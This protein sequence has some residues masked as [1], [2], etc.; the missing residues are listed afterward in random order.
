[1]SD[2]ID[3]VEAN[4]K[5]Y[6][7]AI[8]LAFSCAFF[9]S[10]E[11][12]NYERYLSLLFGEYTDLFSVIASVFLLMFAFKNKTLNFG[13]LILVIA[14]LVLEI[15]YLEAF[16][17]SVVFVAIYY[18]SSRYFNPDLDQDM[19]RP[20]MRTFP[21]G[22]KLSKSIPGLGIILWPI[23]R[24]WYYIW[25]PYGL[26]MTHRGVSHWPLIGTLTRVLYIFG[27]IHLISIFLDQYTA[28]SL[29]LPDL[30]LNEDL[31]IILS[32]LILSDTNHF[33]VDMYDSKRKGNG[34]TQGVRKGLIG[35]VI[36]FKF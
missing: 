34:F 32:P 24:A 17:G 36:G 12:Y 15:S 30:R 9:Y 5:P 27:I 13:I 6:I 29:S 3:N 25:H 26:L 33:I 21:I 35:R 8:I 18:Y 16:R 23:N 10:F 2:L 20:G 14:S 19:L 22:K 1:M 7:L 11:N 31:I 28:H 4:R